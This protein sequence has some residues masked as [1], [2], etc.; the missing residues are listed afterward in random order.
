MKNSIQ[1]L[2]VQTASPMELVKAARHHARTSAISRAL[3][4]SQTQPAQ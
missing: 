4:G 3:S 2:P 1:A